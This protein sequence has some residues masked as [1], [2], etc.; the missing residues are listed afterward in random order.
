MYDF[1]SCNTPVSGL[2]A[3]LCGPVTSRIFFSFWKEHACLIRGF[4]TTTEMFYQ[5]C[6]GKVST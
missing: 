3:R 4:S 6:N 5:C 2:T 1:I